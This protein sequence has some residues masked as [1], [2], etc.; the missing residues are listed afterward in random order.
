[1]V[2]ILAVV[3]SSQESRDFSRERFKFVILDVNPYW[4]KSIKHWVFIGSS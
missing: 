4:V 1:M 2:N 3:G